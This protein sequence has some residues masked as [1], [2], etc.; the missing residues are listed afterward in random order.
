[1]KVQRSIFREYDIRGVVG[2]DLTPDLA[3]AIGRAYGTL[4]S[5]TGG[6]LVT[7][8]H[9]ARLSS[10]SLAEALRAGIRAAGVD[11][12]F[13]GLVPTPALYYSIHH[14]KAAGGVML[15]GSH[16]PPEFNGFKLNLGL[17]SIYG[18]RIQE[19]ADIIENETY[20]AGAGAERS[21]DI[22]EPYI[23]MVREKISLARPLKIVVDA[24]NGCGAI[25]TPRLL[26]ALGC[27]VIELFCEVDGT[28]PNHHPD[29][30]VPENLRDLIATVRETGADA[31]FAYDGD[32]D[33]IGVV[34]EQGNILFGDQI[35]IIFAREILARKPGAAIVYDVKCT[36][37]LEHDIRSRG[38]RPVINPTGHSLIKARLAKEKAELAGEMSAHIFFKDGFFGF[39]DAIYAT[40]R[41]LKIMA[42][43]PRPVSSFLAGLPKTFST[44]EIRVDCPDEEKFEVIKEITAHFKRE[45]PVVDIDGAR[46]DFGGGWALARASNT[47]PALVLRFEADTEARLREIKT[48]VHQRLIQT[49]PLKG[50]A[51]L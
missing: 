11:V 38:G 41:F 10:P 18:A 4:V 49:A 40:A 30:T 21:E 39:D 46:V 1:M 6:T 8:G 48:I 20:A 31:G 44:P 51:P 25:F 34:D 32:A 28:F 43:T 14:F 27:E 26:R 47:Q 50:L 24:G 7:V 9:D 15:T 33:R 22:I 5:R 36:M 17:E 29:P 19:L 23:A 42:E 45:R 37:H 35:L 3:R 16:N 13:V 12:I 2:R